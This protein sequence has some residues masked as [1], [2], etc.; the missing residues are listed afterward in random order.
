MGLVCKRPLISFC[1]LI[2]YL[3]IISSIAIMSR[4]V[5]REGAM[6]LHFGHISLH[7]ATIIMPSSSCTTIA[8]SALTSYTP[9]FKILLFAFVYLLWSFHPQFIWLCPTFS[10][11][12]SNFPVVYSISLL[13]VHCEDKRFILYLS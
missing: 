3:L 7:F 5:E 4:S 12:T 9:V 6:I 10:F 13:P 2:L 11:I 8:P 1:L